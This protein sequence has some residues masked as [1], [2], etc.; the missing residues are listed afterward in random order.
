LGAKLVRGAYL[1]KERRYA[2][3][4]GKDPKVFELKEQT[5]KSF[6]EG[7]ALCIKEAKHVHL[8]IATHNEKSCMKAAKC[9]DENDYALNDKR[10]WFSQLYGMCD[11][12]SFNLAEAGFNVAKY[13]PYGSVSDVVPYLIRR[14]EENSSIAGQSRR[15]LTL[16]RKEM[17]RRSKAGQDK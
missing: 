2:R 17:K 6:D 3:K 11:H 7:A 15:E 1:E 14:A 10:I 9:I 8:C 5:D 16:Y 4:A 12:L 13:I